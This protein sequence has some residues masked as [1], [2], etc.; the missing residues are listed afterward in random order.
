[1][2][3]SFVC[4]VIFLDIIK[5]AYILHLKESIH[6]ELNVIS[7]EKHVIYQLAKQEENYRD[8]PHK[9]YLVHNHR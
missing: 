2:I 5:L 6:Q 1:M 4:V 9:A 3:Y 7:A 8:A